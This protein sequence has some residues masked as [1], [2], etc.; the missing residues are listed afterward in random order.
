M[1]SL[2]GKFVRARPD[3][4][5]VEDARLRQ[6]LRAR[7]TSKVP[8]PTRVGRYELGRV[9]GQGAMGVV[10]EAY[11]RK[12][13]RRVALKLA[14][15][16]DDETGS[17]DEARALAALT[18]LN[19]VEVFDVG[20]QRG[21]MWMAMELVEG[22]T[23]L[24][25]SSGR[26]SWRDR[27]GAVLQLTEGL[28]AVH[29]IGLVH[30]DVKPTNVMVEPDGRVRLMDFGLARPSAMRMP[31][32]HPEQPGSHTGPAGTPGFIAPEV[33]DGVRA[34]ESSDQYSLAKTAAVVLADAPEAVRAVIERGGSVDP[35]KRWSRLD[36][37]KAALERAGGRRRSV[38]RFGWFSLAALG[39]VAVVSAMNLAEQPSQTRACERPSELGGWRVGAPEDGLQW[40]DAA[41][42][43]SRLDEMLEG[44]ELAADDYC[45]R[46]TRGRLRE[47][48]A[49]AA[50]HCLQ[51][52]EARMRAIVAAL[53]SDDPLRQ[54]MGV[55]QLSQRRRVSACVDGAESILSEV[56]AELQ[57]TEI[58]ATYSALLDAQ[59]DAFN[60]EIGAAEESLARARA[61]AV[62][63]DWPPLL[64]EVGLVRAEFRFREEA[65]SSAIE[66][67]EAVYYEAMT[68]ADWPRAAEAASSLQ[69]FASAGRFDLFRAQA[70][71]EHAEAAASR[72]A[73]S[74]AWV[75]GLD[76]QR[77][78][79]LASIRG[80]SDVNLDEV[81]AAL[82]N[83][84]QALGAASPR[85]ALAR[86]RL[87][88]VLGDVDQ[89]ERG[90][91]EA[92]ASLA[93]LEASL[94]DGHPAL[95]FPLNALAN[96]KFRSGELEQA[97]DVL[98]R[99]LDI[100]IAHPSDELPASLANLGMLEA[101]LKN[102]DVAE[103]LL[104]R[105]VEE[106]RRVQGPGGDGV[107]TTLHNLGTLYGIS[108]RREEAARVLQQARS[109]R[110]MYFPPNN[111]ELGWTLLALADLENGQDAP[112]EAARL[113]QRALKIFEA[114]YGSEHSSIGEALLMWGANRLKAKD[115]G[116]ALTP[117]RRAKSIL[118]R[119][120][121]A[122]SVRVRQVNKFLAEAE[123]EAATKAKSETGSAR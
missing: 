100:R 105:S 76:A 6:S 35:A 31:T 43:A 42:V 117:L 96:L 22:D 87:A 99:S 17:L 66:D 61:S 82:T 65:V 118:E 106:Y 37:F 51:Q 33:L 25:W 103:P 122:G 68:A 112:A 52:S 83:M 10:Y 69:L 8:E 79:R 58:E 3:V 113:V 81:Q 40:A 78:S 97:R 28:I 116:E 94:G 20:V 93:A 44:Q 88:T 13:Q 19:V 115:Y 119:T 84:E 70:W 71:R 73:D 120:L 24:A 74:T 32:P 48:E 109:I 91:R 49:R 18:H 47:S 67:A 36:A 77:R 72:C 12:L 59:R 110:E 54:E 104:L 9:L 1:E 89:T 101:Q 15:R 50:A 102:Y 29:R 123:A 11:D 7:L 45:T 80:E 63:L 34:S 114:A 62:Q 92:E 55:I 111:P 38:G 75:V 60:R 4:D 26:S 41:V 46:V 95:T 23:L 64:R 90:V 5:S 16:R 2:S 14:R 107:A 121:P 108:D 57:R 86:A 21:R 56:P 27:L 30:R 53:R 85:V 39:V 98:R